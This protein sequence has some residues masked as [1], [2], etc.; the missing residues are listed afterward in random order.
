VRRG[1]EVIDLSPKEYA[2]LHELM[3]NAGRTLSRAPT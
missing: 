1:G 3:R 2:L